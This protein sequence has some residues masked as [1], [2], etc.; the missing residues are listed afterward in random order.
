MEGEILV[1]DARKVYL[2]ALAERL[3]YVDLPPE[4]RQ[5]GMCARLKRCLY[6]T[7]DAPASLSG[8]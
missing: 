6:G 8:K 5:K 3:V 4:V 2:H 7:R 1:I